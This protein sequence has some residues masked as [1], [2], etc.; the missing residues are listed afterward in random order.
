MK[1]GGFCR[2]Q[3][4][5]SC[6]E[7]FKLH[8][9]CHSAFHEHCVLRVYARYQQLHNHNGLSQRLVRGTLELFKSEIVSERSFWS[10][11]PAFHVIDVRQRVISWY[12]GV[13][14]RAK[15]ENSGRWIRVKVKRAKRRKHRKPAR[16]HEKEK[17]RRRVATQATALHERR[18]VCCE[19]GDAG[20]VVRRW[21][22]SQARINVMCLT[23]HCPRQSRYSQRSFNDITKL[24]RTDLNSVRWN[25]WKCWV[26]GCC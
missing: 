25:R 2:T 23:T 24:S 8:R 1:Y 11:I 15:A 9:I 6:N 20:A 5:A 3:D 19:R 13:W 26:C 21:A 22:Q 4:I 10:P 14:M 17:R 12:R 16:K 18:S 7:I